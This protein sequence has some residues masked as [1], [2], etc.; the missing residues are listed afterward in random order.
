[1][2]LVMQDG[3]P[4][5]KHAPSPYDELLFAN[6]SF[7]SAAGANV[8]FLCAIVAIVAACEVAGRRLWRGPGAPAWRDTNLSLLLVLGVSGMIAALYVYARRANGKAPMAPLASWFTVLAIGGAIAAG[9]AHGAQTRSGDG[10]GAWSSAPTGATLEFVCAGI[11]AGLAL[12]GAVVQYADGTLRVDRLGAAAGFS[13]AAFAS[14]LLSFY[15]IVLFYSIGA[16]AFPDNPAIAG[17]AVA[18]GGVALLTLLALGASALAARLSSTVGDYS[19]V[20]VAS[21]RESARFVRQTRSLVS[22]VTLA[23]IFVPLVVILSSAGARAATVGAEGLGAAAAA[24]AVWLPLATVFA[25]VAI[26]LRALTPR[27]YQTISSLMIAL[28]ILCAGQL[29][30]WTPVT[31]W[32]FAALPMFALAFASTSGRDGGPRKLTVA[33]ALAGGFA[34]AQLLGSKWLALIPAAA[35]LLF[36]RMTERPVAPALI[37]VGAV[38]ASIADNGAGPGLGD[39]TAAELTAR[40][41]ADDGRAALAGRTAAALAAAL[42]VASELFNAANATLDA[43]LGGLADIQGTKASPLARALGVVLVAVFASLAT[44]GAAGALSDLLIYLT[45]GTAA[46][47]QGSASG[48]NGTAAPPDRSMS[49]NT[50]TPASPTPGAAPWIGSLIGGLVGAVLLALLL[51]FLVRRSRTLQRPGGVKPSDTKEMQNATEIKIVKNAGGGDCLFLSFQQALESLK[52]KRKKIPTVEEMRNEVASSLNE[53]QL[54]QLKSIYKGADLEDYKFMEGVKTL[55]DLREKV[56]SREYWGDELAIPVLER[57]TNLRAHIVLKEPGKASFAKRLDEP[58]ESGEFIVLLLDGKHYSLIEL[59]GQRVFRTNEHFP[60]EI[61]S[62]YLKTVGLPN[63]DLE[64]QIKLQSDERKN[65]AKKALTAIN[66]DIKKTE[67]LLKQDIK[68][69]EA[70]LKQEQYFSEIKQYVEDAE[71][72][73]KFRK[74]E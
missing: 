62:A 19:G 46:A 13:A 29:I 38:L 43:A 27:A 6:A 47:A 55:N 9:F 48:G 49:V 64:N 32:T 67:A 24:Y 34:A 59:N 50:T 12:L 31:V 57:M 33:L 11:L 63:V 36:L 40:A 30:P 56:K 69:T 20:P 39:A 41:L 16:D 60:D 4:A 74:T 53:N 23:A 37:F 22:V 45:P 73:K 72:A 68:K 7:S 8:Y 26:R 21:S 71:N 42:L 1:M 35:V 28:V 2:Q 15:A 25:V 5:D 66:E 52:R 54:E 10:A 65:K 14:A 51:L 61:L 18:I 58:H 17:G 70:L 3:L 44:R